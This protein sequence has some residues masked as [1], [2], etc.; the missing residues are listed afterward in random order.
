MVTGKFAQPLPGGRLPLLK[1]QHSA[2]VAR[3]IC[4]ESCSFKDI[5]AKV[6]RNRKHVEIWQLH[7][8]LAS[9]NVV[10][11][12]IWILLFFSIPRTPPP[13][14]HTYWIKQESGNFNLT[15]ISFSPYS[16]THQ[17][18]LCIEGFSRL[19]TLIYFCCY[20]LNLVHYDQ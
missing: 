15:S 10:D 5:Y 4:F 3:T 1:T 14:T 8:E 7:G 20:C 2:Q 19:F 13:H 18:C 9:N 17:S 11:I 12:H 6:V 16:S